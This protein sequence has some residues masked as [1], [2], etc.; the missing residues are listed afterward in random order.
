MSTTET[1]TQVA[2]RC[3][4]CKKILAFKLGTASGYL[5]LKCPVFVPGSNTSLQN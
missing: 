4:N 1:G 3:E 5:Q 2:V